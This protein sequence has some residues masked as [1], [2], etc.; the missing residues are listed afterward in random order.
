MNGHIQLGC[1]PA[2]SAHVAVPPLISLV[3]E[4]ELELVESQSAAAKAMTIITQHH[5]LS[6]FLPSS[7]S[8]PSPSSRCDAARHGKRHLTAKSGQS[9]DAQTGRGHRRQP[10]P[11]AVRL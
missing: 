5:R 6:L 7:M 3:W 10:D 11:L 4:F 2:V 9:P 1:A 8:S